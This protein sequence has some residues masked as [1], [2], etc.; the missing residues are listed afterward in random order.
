VLAL[1]APAAGGPAA[2]PAAGAP[3]VPSLPVLGFQE[4]SEKLARIDENAGAI[5]TVGVDGVNLIASGASFTA[6]ERRAVS[7][8]T[9]AHADHLG[10]IL[11]IGNFDESIED[12]NETTAFALLGDPS[13]IVSVAST[14]AADVSAE[15]P[16]PV[17]SLSW[18]RAGLAIAL[19]SIKAAEI[20]LGAAGYGYLWGPQGGFQVS[21]A[22]ARSLVAEDGARARFSEHTGEWMAKLSGRRTIFWSDARS[23]ALKAGIALQ[24]GL[25]GMAVWSLGLSDPI[26]LVPA[27]SA[28]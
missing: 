18:T 2:Q 8:L 14:L 22:E 6:P 26:V 3:A 15:G 20:D 12:F 25:H 11:L 10:A 19:Q 4:A 28:S 21:D 1:T 7:Q 9:R 23:Y 13:H 17:G 5:S 16:G 24:H 27:P